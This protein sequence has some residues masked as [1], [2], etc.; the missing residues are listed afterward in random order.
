MFP[1]LQFRLWY[2]KINTLNTQYYNVIVFDMDLE[3][4]VSP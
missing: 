1:A 4:C 2:V 3:H